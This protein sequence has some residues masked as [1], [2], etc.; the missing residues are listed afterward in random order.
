MNRITILSPSVGDD[1]GG[2]REATAVDREST[3]RV[4]ADPDDVLG[5]SVEAVV[6]V[7]RRR[8]LDDE[9]TEQATSDLVGGVVVRVV[10]VRPRRSRGELVGEAPASRDRLL[11]DVGH[12]IHR[13]GQ[14]LTVE[15]DAGRLSQVVL[16]DRADLVAL[17]DRDPRTRPRSVVA[18]RR[19][20]RHDRVD[21]MLD[22]V[23]RQLEDL[24]VAV[25]PRLER[26][27]AHRVGRRLATEEAL[28]AGLG[29]RV[30]VDRRRSRR[31]RRRV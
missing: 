28:D 12:A 19:D 18:E 31:G 14:P 9:R 24:D 2:R 15:V 13:V 29:V 11:G 20:R 22:L 8:R 6:A 30:V 1:R 25:E 4:V 23:D 16:E 17:G 26:L 7:G 3:E 21:P 27:V 5:R 10:H